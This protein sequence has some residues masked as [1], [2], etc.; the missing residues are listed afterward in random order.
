MQTKTT[1]SLVKS[2]LIDKDQLEKSAKLIQGMSRLKEMNLLV[3]KDLNNVKLPGVIRHPHIY[4][5]YH[6][7]GSNPGYSRG[8]LG[9]HYAH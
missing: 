9:R 4:N 1:K 5:D 8:E 6:T 2:L 7:R 3:G